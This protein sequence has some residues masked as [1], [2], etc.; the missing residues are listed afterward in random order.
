MKNPAWSN[1]IP[2]A[3]TYVE[4]FKL[5]DQVSQLAKKQFLNYHY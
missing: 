4:L 2:A 1:Q 5:V 3:K